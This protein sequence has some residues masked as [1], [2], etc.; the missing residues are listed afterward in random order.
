MHAAPYAL[1]IK[2]GIAAIAAIIV[3]GYAYNR[4]YA[5]IAGPQIE[6]SFPPDGATLNESLVT[7][8]G[9]ATNITALTLN[10][11]EISVA[12]NGRVSETVLLSYG[13]NVITFR[14]RDRFG[15]NAA[16]VRHVVY[17]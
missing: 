12:Q 13:Y 15:R 5:L 8:T 3:F 14:A 9:R 4:S 6:I 7:I 10:G 16:A 2:M 11:R 17:K 1:R